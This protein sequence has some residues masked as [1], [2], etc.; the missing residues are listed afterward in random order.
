MMKR[1]S[2][3]QNAQIFVEY[4]IVVGAILLVIFAMSTMLKRATQ[5]MVKVVADEI[6]LQ[7]NADQRF[8]DKGYLKN[9][10]TS[11]RDKTDKTLKEISGV[12]GYI[13]NDVSMVSSE[14]L[15]NMGWTNEN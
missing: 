2:L 12:V 13:F 3:D 7:E 5:G 4:T 15:I 14:K 9:S 1:C 6:G 8:D 11:R 10:Y